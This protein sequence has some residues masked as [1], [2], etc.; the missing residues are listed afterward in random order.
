[1]AEVFKP[2]TTIMQ[3]I[4]LRSDNC[5][6]S[7]INERLTRTLIQVSLFVSF[8]K[9]LLSLQLENTEERTVKVSVRWVTSIPAPAES[10]PACEVTALP[11]LI[12]HDIIFLFWNK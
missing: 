11:D 5:K 3:A 10:E 9:P 12:L 4:S 6:K 8:L 1:M 2:P 7:P